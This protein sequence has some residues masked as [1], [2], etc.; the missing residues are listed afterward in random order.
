MIR[1]FLPNDACASRHVRFLLSLFVVCHQFVS[2]QISCLGTFVDT[3]VKRENLFRQRYLPGC[4]HIIKIMWSISFVPS[5]IVA[6]AGF[7]SPSY[8]FPSYLHY[9]APAD[10]PDGQCPF[11]ACKTSLQINA[12]DYAEIFCSEIS[13]PAFPIAAYLARYCFY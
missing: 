3:P 12:S 1:G 4:D 2:S 10:R 6:Y 5:P 8:R 13:R 11:P 9:Y 7:L